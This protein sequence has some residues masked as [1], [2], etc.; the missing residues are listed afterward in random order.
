MEV[1]KFD[2]NSDEIK[3]L[4]EKD[5]KIKKLI[6]LIG[7][8]K[9]ELNKNY[10]QSLIG[11]IIS[12]SFS[13][14]AADKIYNRFLDLV[15]KITPENILNIDDDML[16]SVGISKSKITYI[17]NLCIDVIN[18]KIDL[19]NIEDLANEDIIKILTTVKG[20]GPWTAEIFLIFS[21]GRLDIF[22]TNDIGLKRALEWLYGIEIS[23]IQRIS[24]DWAPYRTIV[25][26]YLWEL[27]N[28]KYIK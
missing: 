2:S 15:G 28:R 3:Y 7:D 13:K 8:Y 6:E 23:D 24:F 17:K 25:A 27:I 9:L 16:K 12:Q 11:I 21:I 14:N 5:K 20:I 19:N 22:P 10:F 18:R 4:I 26:L 1:L